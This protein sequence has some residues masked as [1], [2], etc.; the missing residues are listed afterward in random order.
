MRSYSI[1]SVG[2]DPSIEL[3]VDRLPTGEVSPYLVDDVLPG[4]QLEVRGPLGRWFVTLTAEFEMPDAELPPVEPG[5]VVGLD[6]GL[7]DFAVLSDG[8]RIHAPKFYRNAQRKLRKAQRVVSRRKP[9]SD[10]K[11]K[12]RRVVA[13]MRWTPLARPRIDDS[14]LLSRYPFSTFVPR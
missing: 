4:D 10:R 1:A 9:G 3:A 13:K 6:L 11:A 7:K 8:T 2:D 14:S 12:A 5:G